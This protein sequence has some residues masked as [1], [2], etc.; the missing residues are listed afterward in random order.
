MF[1]FPDFACDFNGL[2]NTCGYFRV[3]DLLFGVIFGFGVVFWWIYGG[4]FLEDVVCMY[5]F[6]CPKV[7]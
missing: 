3:S 5:C 4:C 7:F 6:F 1:F 2:L